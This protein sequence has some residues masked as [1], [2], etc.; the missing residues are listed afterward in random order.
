M[1]VVMSAR[2]TNKWYPVAEPAV[3][4]PQFAGTDNNA[5]GPEQ[6]PRSEVE[7]WPIRAGLRV[8]YA[9]ASWFLR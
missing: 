9:W 8:A 2:G 7:Y 4:D 1:F 3:D 5:V 6:R